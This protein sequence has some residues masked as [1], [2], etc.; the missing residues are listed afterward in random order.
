MSIVSAARRDTARGEIGTAPLVQRLFPWV[1]PGTARFRFNPASNRIAGSVA[2]R[3]IHDRELAA[4][5]PDG[6]LVP[7]LPAVVDNS[8]WVAT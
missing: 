5:E 1:A 3:R 7:M 8:R 4:S 6:T 2:A